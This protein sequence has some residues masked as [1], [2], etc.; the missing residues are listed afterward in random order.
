VKGGDE[1]TYDHSGK[2]AEYAPFSYSGP[3]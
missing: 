3:S 2:Q 1:V